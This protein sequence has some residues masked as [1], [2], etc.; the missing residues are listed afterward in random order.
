MSDANIIT[1][2]IKLG[3][4]C[5]LGDPIQLHWMP[6]EMPWIAH[7]DCIYPA[8]AP[9]SCIRCPH[10][11]RYYSGRW[12]TKVLRDMR[13]EKKKKEMRKVAKTWR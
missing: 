4:M 1:G 3:S 12:S 9:I 13:K 6:E 2:R 5:L 10:Y 7:K 8:E 11:R